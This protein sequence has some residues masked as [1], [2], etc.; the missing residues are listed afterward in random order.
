MAS[1]LRELSK[2]LPPGQRK[3]WLPHQ[4]ARERARNLKRLQREALQDQTDGCEW[5][6]P[7]AEGQSPAEH[8]EARDAD[9]GVPGLP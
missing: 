8:Q 1:V 5:L 7:G 9:A 6:T 4:G 2:G 3:Q